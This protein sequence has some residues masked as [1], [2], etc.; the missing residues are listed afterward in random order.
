MN[1][2]AKHSSLRCPE[3]TQFLE[4]ISF[5]LP[6]IQMLLDGITVQWQTFNDQETAFFVIN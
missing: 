3:R 2:I 4:G 5:T 1:T 6:H